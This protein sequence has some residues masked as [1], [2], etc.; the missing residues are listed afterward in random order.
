[1]LQQKAKKRTQ[2]DHQPNGPGEK[3]LFVIHNAVIKLDHVHTAVYQSA[4]HMIS[5][6]ISAYK[7]VLVFFF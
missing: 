5:D 1:M 2:Q 7:S 3:K 6:F 4:I